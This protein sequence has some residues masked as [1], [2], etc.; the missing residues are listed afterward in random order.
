MRF[1]WSTAAAARALHAAA[2]TIV[3][4]G[5]LGCCSGRGGRRDAVNI[6]CLSLSLPHTLTKYNYKTH[7]HTNTQAIWDKYFSDTHAVLFVVDA[8]NSERL[9]ESKAAFERVIGAPDLAGAPVLVV[10]N[11]QDADGAAAMTEV[12]DA[13]G[14]SG[15]GTAGGGAPC[16]V[17]P[18]SAHTGAGLTDGMQWLVEAVKKSPRRRLVSASA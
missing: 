18:A 13:L 11:K 10:A 7:A 8:T 4:H 1:C 12:S 17:Q 14:L 3:G 16:I 9:E 5:S 2:S 6:S 15:G